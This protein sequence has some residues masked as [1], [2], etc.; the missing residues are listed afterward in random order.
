MKK[1]NQM[2]LYIIFAFTLVFS[3][4]TSG[5]SQPE[6]VTQ[7]YEPA[8]CPCGGQ[9]E[10]T[11]TVAAQPA[12]ASQVAQAPAA[13][14]DDPAGKL[15]PAADL[16]MKSTKEGC[17]EVRA[18]LALEAATADNDD[19]EAVD[20]AT[21][22]EDTPALAKTRTTTPPAPV[23]EKSAPDAH[24]A[25]QVDLNA[26]TLAELM[27]LPGVGPATAAR[28]IEYRKKRRFEATAHL[29]RVKGIGKAKYARIAPR[30]VV[31]PPVALARE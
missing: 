5:C 19:A 12:Q 26:A 14:E 17:D 27:T 2:G 22:K 16:K 21:P 30:V 1:L 23:D 24:P 7:A 29:M 20:A 11:K 25:Q 15:Q 8:E 10:G 6:P 31:R 13:G 28:I 18:A 3:L 9:A 4:T